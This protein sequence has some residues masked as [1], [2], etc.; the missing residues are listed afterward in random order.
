MA[1][2]INISGPRAVRTMERHKQKL[3]KCPLDCGVDIFPLSIA[4]SKEGEVTAEDPNYDILALNDHNNMFYVHTGL[5]WVTGP[6]TFTMLT[7]RSSSIEKLNGGRVAQ[8]IIDANYTGEIMV[9]ITA[10][11]AELDDVI[12]GVER[13][14]D[15]NLAIAQMIPLSFFYAGLELKTEGNIILPFGAGRGSNG[16]GSTDKLKG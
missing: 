5:Y 8:G 16:F 7:E 13:C 14:I 2:L 15:E 11:T 9:R 10:G 6:N 3:A 1:T 12:A 4:V